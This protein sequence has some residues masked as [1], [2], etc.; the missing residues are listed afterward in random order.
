MT[1]CDRCSP[2]DKNKTKAPRRGWLLLEAVLHGGIFKGD[3]GFSH[4]TQWERIERV[5]RER[6]GSHGDEE[7]ADCSRRREE[8]DGG[9]PQVCWVLSSSALY[10]E[11]LWAPQYFCPS[12]VFQRMTWSSYS[13]WNGCQDWTHSLSNSSGC[14]IS[15]RREK[16]IIGIFKG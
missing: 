15:G 11:N 4:Q 3:D 7:W 14:E 16:D 9:S 12:D 2:R 8:T 13:K 5:C 1:R 10:T 6:H